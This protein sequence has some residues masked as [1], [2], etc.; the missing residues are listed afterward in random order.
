MSRKRRERTGRPIKR[1]HGRQAPKSLAAQAKALRAAQQLPRRL[2]T[3]GSP[4]DAAKLIVRSTFSF[5]PLMVSM[6]AGLSSMRR[7]AEVA[8]A[9]VRLAPA[10][11]RALAFAAQAALLEGDQ[12]RALSFL[13]RA[14]SSGEADEGLR[15]THAAVLLASG[16]I[17]EAIREVDFLCL[18]DPEGFG[19]Q[20]LRAEALTLMQR[21]VTGP[22]G[23]A[24]SCGSGRPYVACCREAEADALRRF[25]D[26]ADLDALVATVL[27]YLP[28]LDGFLPFAAEPWDRAYRSWHGEGYVFSS[29]E[30]LL[31]DLRAAGTVGPPP[32]ETEPEGPNALF[33]VLELLARLPEVRGGSGDLIDAWAGGWAMLGVWQVTPDQR[34]PGTMVTDLLTGLRVYADLGA[35]TREE[36]G[37]WSVFVGMIVSFDGLWRALPGFVALSPSEA[38]ILVARVHELAG[39]ISERDPDV[40]SERP[41]ETIPHSMWIEA[42][43]APPA[44]VALVA[45]T[46][47]EFL[48]EV[49][50]ES[51]AGRT[52][53]A[54]DDENVQVRAR[55]TADDIGAIWTGLVER[56]DILCHRCDELW[57][58]A[59]LD[60]GDD[61]SASM[62]N[63]IRMDD[64]S[65]AISLA[66]A[67]HLDRL[68]AAIGD[69][70]PS[71]MVAR[72][73]TRCT[74]APPAPWA[75]PSGVD[76]QAIALWEQQWPDEASFALHCCTPR[77]A[78]ESIDSQPQLELVLREL[79]FHAERVRREGRAAPDMTAVRERLGMERPPTVLT[80][81]AAA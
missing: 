16:R 21:R 4:D 27:A 34:G 60:S 18:G 51:L 43:P 22:A 33:T 45:C 7:V 56:D 12:D 65:L 71:A 66:S 38:D 17:A 64:G 40:P 58:L 5:P 73:T 55:I 36:L 48:P 8:A 24:C 44:V 47:L 46:A 53:L 81:A 67:G 26:R 23:V 78:A 15:Q 59:R 61:G 9:A 72:K 20:S 69:I 11:R 13:N 76:D 37:Q 77:E 79:E 70:E 62:Q 25:G 63:T 30:I 54:I 31:R 52:R 19:P 35:G 41:V 49:L 28:D 1:F 80:V 6:V 2:A 74:S 29:S 14:L 10:N 68:L 50:A 32:D 57:W 75:A 3:E 39:V 42:S